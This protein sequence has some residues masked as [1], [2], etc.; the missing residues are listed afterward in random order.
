VSVGNDDAAQA[1]FEIAEVRIPPIGITSAHISDV[2][3]DH[4]I[5]DREI[6]PIWP[7]AQ[8]ADA[9]ALTVQVPPGDNRT[10]FEAIDL[11]KAGQAILVSGGGY[12]GRSLWGA[13]MS[14]AAC[15][16]GVVGLVVDGCVRDKDDIEMMRFP[17]FARGITPINPRPIAAGSINTTIQ[18][19]GIQVHPGDHVFADSDGI[20][21]I[22]R[23]VVSQVT[24]RAWER[25]QREDRIFHELEQGTSLQDALQKHPMATDVETQKE[26]KA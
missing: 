17:V 26:E 14:Y 5:M 3:K 6:R 8:I 25:A 24:L 23:E 22:R 1:S 4:V 12:L 19:G 13:I 21:V 9:P 20:A 15:Q 10:L 16:R 7:G 2:A 18:C 11:A